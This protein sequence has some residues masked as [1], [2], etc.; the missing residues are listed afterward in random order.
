[1]RASR[2]ASSTRAT[3]PSVAKDADIA[4]LERH[5]A[6]MLGVSV[7]ITHSAGHRGQLTLDYGSLEQLDM[8][9]QRLSGEQ[10]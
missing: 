7:R 10:I 1:V 6:D 5:L 8:L 3:R 2:H 9:C 4:A